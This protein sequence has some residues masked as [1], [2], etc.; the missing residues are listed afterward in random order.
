MAESTSNPLLASSLGDDEPKTGAKLMSSTL[1][2]RNISFEVPEK[3]ILKDIN[4]SVEPG[5]LLCIM[6]PSGAGKS[7]MLNL[8]AGRLGSGGTVSGDLLSD[9]NVIDPTT[10]RSKI[11]YVMQE[12]AL[13]A[14]Q[15][16][17]EALEFSAA[18]RLPKRF[19]AQER[20]ALVEDMLDELGLIKCADTYVGSVMLRGV[21]GGEK[22]RTAIGVELIS[23]PEILFLD[24]PTSGLDSYA[25]YNVV[26][27]LGELAQCGVTIVCTIHQ[28]SSE[29]FALF[30]DCMLLAD[31]RLVY[32]GT[33]RAMLP[34]F[35]SIGFDCQ[36]NYNPADFVMFLMQE[37]ASGQGSTE[38]LAA[39]AEH[40]SLLWTDRTKQDPESGVSEHT[41]TSTAR[42]NTKS[43]NYMDRLAHL[44]S[45]D[46]SKH[47][48]WYQFGWLVQREGRNVL[49]NKGALYAMVGV[50]ITLNLI[51][52]LVFK[53]AGKWSDS[54]EP[55]ELAASIT[56]HS[57][58]LTQVAIGAMFGLAQPA[59]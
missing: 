52:G 12:D 21:S 45:G 25:A 53:G 26:K 40:L 48:T 51:I 9:S 34:Y 8:L 36:P 17:R 44:S 29:V 13:F 42:R 2:W 54:T 4:G 5:R 19:T 27:L 35:S 23:Q 14:T 24:E 16:P 30:D 28:P 57:S 39:H 6:G 33:R 10:F 50:T 43:S 11:A 20:T 47:G 41:P 31:G 56:D 55:V 7:T 37:D 32:H 18:L 46:N 49:R 3:R 59:L 1:S 38:S 15:T 58:A 22:K